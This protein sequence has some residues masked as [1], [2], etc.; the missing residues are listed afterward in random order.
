MFGITA[1]TAL[2]GTVA[3]FWIFF[4]KDI[5]ISIKEY[6]DILAIGGIVGMCLTYPAGF[7]ADKYHPLRVQLAMKFIL[8]FF[9]PMY[10]IF[11]LSTNT[12]NAYYHYLIIAMASLPAGTLYNAAVLPALM[13]LFPKERYGQFCSADAMVRSVATIFGGLVAG[14]TFDLIKWS[15][16][17]STFAYRW[18]PLW[19]FAFDFLAFL[20]LI[21]VYQG[22][23][24]YGGLKNYV[25]PLPGNADSI[26]AAGKT[27]NV[28]L[29]K[30]QQQAGESPAPA[31]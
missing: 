15:V 3:I 30:S 12:S 8:L 4:V 21:K 27:E 5:G 20:C 10:L 23:K 22:W 16:G 17:G 26:P 29:P 1:F 28:E 2:S 31:E 14:A 11:L 7:V 13:R 19:Q 18:I 24:H 6:G 9:T 25:P